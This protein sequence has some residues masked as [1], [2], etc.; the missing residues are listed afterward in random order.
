[1]PLSL[2]DPQLPADPGDALQSIQRNFDALATASTPP[3]TAAATNAS[4][5]TG[6]LTARKY[7]DGLVILEGELSKAGLV[8]GDSVATLPSGF[9]PGAALTNIPIAFG[10]DRSAVSV[11]TAGAITLSALAPTIGVVALNHASFHA[12]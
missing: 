7:A 2:P 12:A 10:T 1:M 3:V 9:R 6:T 8:A 4:G 5:V 11:S